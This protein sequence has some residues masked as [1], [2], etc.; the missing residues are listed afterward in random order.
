MEDTI[1][2]EFLGEMK[3]MAEQ[4]HQESLIEIEEG[5]GS[6]LPNIAKLLLK[7]IESGLSA[8][9]KFEEDGKVGALNYIYFS[10]LRTSFFA[11]TSNYRLDFYDSNNR[12]SLVECS[13]PWNFDYIFNYF[14]NIKFE[15][16][17]KLENQTRV[18]AYEADLIVFEKAEVYKKMADKKLDIVLRY[19]VEQEKERLFGGRTVKFYRG[20]FFDRITFMFQWDLDHILEPEDK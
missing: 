20:D 16:H 17:K 3:E 10:F 6:E 9:R 19:I 1:K 8:Y 5:F 7:S 13:E 18:K 4:M 11:E 15:I 12:V 2:E 14:N